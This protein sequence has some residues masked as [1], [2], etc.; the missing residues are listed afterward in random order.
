M[1]NV[2][3]NQYQLI[4][5]LWKINITSKLQP[6]FLKTVCASVVRAM[7]W[8]NFYQV[9]FFNCFWLKFQHIYDFYSRL[10][11]MFILNCSISGEPASLLQTVKSLLNDCIA[12]LKL[13]LIYFDTCRDQYCMLPQDTF[14][15]VLCFSATKTWKLGESNRSI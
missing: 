10:R 3:K 7:H 6:N 2:W 15:C 12:V 11:H 9:H 13:T 5:T 1:I 4:L 14:L 8:F